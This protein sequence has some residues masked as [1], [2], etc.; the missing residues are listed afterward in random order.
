MLKCETYNLLVN[1]KETILAPSK[2]RFKRPRSDLNV[3]TCSYHQ[4]KFAVLDRL[5]RRFRALNGVFS[6][7]VNE[8]SA[9]MY[10]NHGPKRDLLN[11]I[12]RTYQ[13]GNHDFGAQTIEMNE[14]TC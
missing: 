13:V 1:S 2:S 9:M 8:L 14:K 10:C 6:A 12:C 7:K 3:K 11:G 4:I 5:R